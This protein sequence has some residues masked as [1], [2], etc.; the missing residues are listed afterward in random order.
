MGA[1]LISILR[2]KP[3]KR[4]QYG[5]FSVGPI[6]VDTATNKAARLNAAPSLIARYVD[7]PVWHRELVAFH[8]FVATV[9][10]VAETGFY[11]VGKP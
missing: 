4:E 1:L 10:V 2:N 8:N 6:F 3:N 11:A 9:A 5:A 7:L